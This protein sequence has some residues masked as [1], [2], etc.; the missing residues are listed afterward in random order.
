M[1]APAAFK[2]G[3]ESA[4]DAAPA[5]VELRCRYAPAPSHTGGSTTL[6]QPTNQHRLSHQVDR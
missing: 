4:H 1:M 2:A 3:W 5:G 6:N